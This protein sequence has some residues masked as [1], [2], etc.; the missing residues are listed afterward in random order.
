MA[1]GRREGYRVK[2]GHVRLKV[3]NMDRAISFYTRMLHMRLVEK[4]G[5]EYAFLS[6][7]DSYH[8]VALQR[9]SE[10]APAPAAE[11]T[12]VDHVAFELADQQELA[13]AFQALSEAGVTP[14]TVDNGIS[15][16]MYFSDPDGNPLEFFCDTRRIP[17]GRERWQGRVEDL[18]PAT[19]LGVLR[20]G[21]HPIA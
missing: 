14:R 9:L 10:A 1:E 7:S 16:A 19:I 21:K 6:G 4:V 8:E 5:N 13:R 15:W 12:G 20:E 2:L 11:A 18:A 17:G 3:R